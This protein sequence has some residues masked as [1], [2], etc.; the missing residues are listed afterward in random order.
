MFRT[1]YKLYPLLSRRVL[2]NIL[3]TKTSEKVT[4]KFLLFICA[5]ILN[6]V[7]HIFIQVVKRKEI[8][9]YN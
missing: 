7:N 4:P 2:F 1:V 3:V 9:Y 6:C 8:F 5:K